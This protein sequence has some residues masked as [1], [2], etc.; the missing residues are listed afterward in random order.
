MLSNVILT[1]FPFLSNL[2]SFC[3]FF[4]FSSKNNITFILRKNQY[5]IILFINLLF[6]EFLSSK[7]INHFN[8]LLLNIL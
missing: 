1:F 7:I 5:L 8:I 2:F 4:Y 3:V 6:N